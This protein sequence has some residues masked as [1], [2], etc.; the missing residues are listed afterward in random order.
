MPPI[1]L[2]NPNT[3]APTTDMMVG[4]ARRYLPSGT[5]IVGVT[6]RYGVPMILD[7]AQLLAAAPEVVDVGIHASAN[8]RGIVVGAFG[9]PG[10]EALRDRLAIPVVGLCEASMIAA[11]A[12]D[13]R[14]GIATVTPGLVEVLARKAD[15]LGIRH[16]FTGTRLTDGDPQMLAAN[17]IELERALAG[18]VERCLRDDGAEAVIIGGGPLG[19]AAA[20]LARQFDAP[21][22]APIPV[23]VQM[24]LAQL[25]PVAI[26]R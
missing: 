20:D 19:Q 12:G 4:I 7:E 9:D 2:I 13:R 8:V 26:A 14:F 22:I 21:V 11:S 25:Q 1:L 15:E 6:A 23:A 10:M 17:A 5:G 3:S 24:L 18:A 16:L